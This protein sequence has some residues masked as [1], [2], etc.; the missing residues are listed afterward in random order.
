MIIF[1]SKILS[2]FKIGDALLLIGFGTA[3]ALKKR[4]KTAKTTCI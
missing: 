2:V 4:K 1:Q 3:Y